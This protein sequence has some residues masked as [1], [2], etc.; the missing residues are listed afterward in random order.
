MSS[1]ILDPYRAIGLVTSD[2]P[3]V[4]NNLGTQS[5]LTV[6]IG[7]AFQVF[8]CEKLTLSLVSPQLQHDIRYVYVTIR[9]C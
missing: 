8:K 7:N 5:F 1:R 9:V 3:F 2:V 6:A 4:L